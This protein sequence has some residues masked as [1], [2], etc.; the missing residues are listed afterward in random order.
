MDAKDI[1]ILSLT[2]VLIKNVCK[3]EQCEKQLDYCKAEKNKS[4]C[5]YK[6]YIRKC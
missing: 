2:Y 1:V 4:C 6:K 3:K 5:T